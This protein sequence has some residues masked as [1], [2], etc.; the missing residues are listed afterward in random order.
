[1]LLR[2]HSVVRFSSG[3]RNIFSKE[4]PGK[5]VGRE[6]VMSHKPGTFMAF[7]PKSTNGPAQRLVVWHDGSLRRPSKILKFIPEADRQNFVDTLSGKTT[8]AA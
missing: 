4:E 7:A 2:S 8:E 3:F 5:V 6:M 1:M